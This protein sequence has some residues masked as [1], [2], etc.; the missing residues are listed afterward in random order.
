MNFPGTQPLAT[1]LRRGSQ[2]D[3]ARYS[4]W[5]DAR[6]VGGL[7][8]MTYAAF[9]GLQSLPDFLLYSTGFAANRELPRQTMEASLLLLFVCA[10][11]VSRIHT[12]PPPGSLFARLL[13][14]S[15]PAGRKGIVS[16]SFKELPGDMFSSGAWSPT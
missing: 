13:S 5:P 12:R 7:F 8:E 3:H 10:P 2:D 9:C 15:F 1:M 11:K 14:K 6:G 16:Y 4:N